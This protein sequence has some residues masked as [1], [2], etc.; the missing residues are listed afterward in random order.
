MRWSGE[1]GVGAPVV[2]ARG[3]V[4]Q[5]DTALVDTAHG[6]AYLDA[7]AQLHRYRVVLR[8]IEGMALT[9]VESRDLI[10]RLVQR[11]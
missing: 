6:G 5:L 3:P 1:R 11:M 10:H 7:E 8:A 2:Y 9:V 4:P